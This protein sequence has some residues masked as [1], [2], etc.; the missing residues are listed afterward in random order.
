M[1]KAIEAA[2][3]GII[4]ADLGGQVIKQRMGRPQQ[5]KSGDYR[6]II[7]FKKDDK[8]FFVYGYAKNQRDNIEEDELNAFKEMS[9]ELFNLSEEDIEKAIND[10]ELTE[11]Q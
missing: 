10:N 2:E 1:K 9:K 5:G 11:V 3:Q 8:A 7:L 4:D 6:T